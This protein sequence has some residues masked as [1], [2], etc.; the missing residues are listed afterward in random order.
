VACWYW[1]HRASRAQY[2]RSLSSATLSPSLPPSLPSSLLPLFPFR[3]A[4]TCARFSASLRSARRKTTSPP[5][6]CSP[7]FSRTSVFPP[8]PHPPPACPGL[9]TD[10]SPSFLPPPSAPER[11]P[12]ERGPGPQGHLLQARGSPRMCASGLPPGLP[13]SLFRALPPFS[14]EPPP[15][16]GRGSDPLRTRI[17]SLSFSSFPSRLP[18]S[19]LHPSPPPATDD[20]DLREKAD[21][22]RFLADEVRFRQV[23]R[24]G[25]WEGTVGD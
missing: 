22:G 6:S 24:E 11:P 10:P 12:P 1:M 16:L 23:R 25:R 5:C 14:L 19:S 2:M 17:A 20:P 21:Y 7:A 13:P 4:S 15:V 9:L 18:P 3:M 8:S